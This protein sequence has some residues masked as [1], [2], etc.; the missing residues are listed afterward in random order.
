MKLEHKTFKEMLTEASVGTNDIFRATESIVKYLG[1]QLSAV[2]KEIDGQEYAN[3]TGNYFG[4]L[5]ICSENNAALRVNWDGNTFHSI[6]YWQNYATDL[7][8]TL[9][10][11]TGKIAP[12]QS[13]FARLLPEIAE[14]IKNGGVPS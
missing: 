13:S 9:E 3:S 10:I 7:V 5:Y 14:I 4:F 11:F 6:N 2:F 8:P 12:G 1:K